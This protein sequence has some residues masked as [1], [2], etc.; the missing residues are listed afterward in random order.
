MFTFRKLF[1]FFAN[2]AQRSKFWQNVL[3]NIE[4]LVRDRKLVKVRN[5]GERSKFCSKVE[6][7]LKDRNFD[8]S[9]K[10]C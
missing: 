9:S 1:F 7:S 5:F 10:F 4:I 3:Y 2:F 6:I 8:E